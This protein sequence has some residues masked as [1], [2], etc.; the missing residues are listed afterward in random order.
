[1]YIDHS[2]NMSW[3]YCG[4]DYEECNETIVYPGIL[5]VRQSCKIKIIK[6]FSSIIKAMAVKAEIAALDLFISK[7]LVKQRK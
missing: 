3:I 4:H 1:M 7:L 6:D 5:K 2:D